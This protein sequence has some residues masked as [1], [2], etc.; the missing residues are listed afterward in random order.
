VQV[1]VERPQM[2][3]FL[4]HTTAETH[5]LI[6]ANLAETPVYGG[7]VDAKGPRYCPSIEDKIVRFRDKDS[8]QVR[9]ALFEVKASLAAH[10]LAMRTPRI[11]CC[12]CRCPSPRHGRCQHIILHPC[13]RGQSQTAHLAALHMCSPAPCHSSQTEPQIQCSHIAGRNTPDRPCKWFTGCC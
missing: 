9:A 13:G 3:C 1:H 6:E 12:I 2:D 10:V 5:A 8:H 7:W 4:T 11:T